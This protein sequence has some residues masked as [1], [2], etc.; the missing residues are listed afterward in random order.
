MG[1]NVVPILGNIYL[2]KLEKSL[3]GKCKTAKK[4]ILP[5]LQ[6]RYIDDGFGVTEGSK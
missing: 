2:A 1:T 3:L 6:I 5:I 4:M